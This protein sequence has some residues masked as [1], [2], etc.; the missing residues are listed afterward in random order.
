M[1]PC[2]A[3]ALRPLLAL[4]AGCVMSHASVADTPEEVR[5]LLASGDLLSAL[6]RAQ[7]GVAARPGD[8]QSRFVLGVVLMDLGRDEQALVVFN[9]LSQTYPELPDP[10]NNIALLQARAG[11]LEPARQSLEAALRNDPAHRAARV[12][13][14]QVHLMLAAQAWSQ[15]S[16]AMPG[17]NALLQKLQGVRALL[18][19]SGR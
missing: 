4:I 7:A 3:S 13:L 12:N 10:L 5:A 16:A 6:V 19:P 2:R 8:A 17:D 9:E 15:A 14:G 11:Q 1:P 18:A